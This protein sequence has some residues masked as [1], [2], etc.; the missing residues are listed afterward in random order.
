VRVIGFPSDSPPPDREAWSA[1]LDAALQG[2]SSGPVAQSWRELSEDVRS[3]APSMTPAFEARMRAELERAGALKGH[4]AVAAAPEARRDPLPLRAL[5]RL[6]RAP[7]KLTAHRGP[8]LAGTALA[9]VAV[10]AAVLAVRPSGSAPPVAL[11]ASTQR[12]P[13]LASPGAVRAEAA[14]STATPEVPSASVQSGQAGAGAPGRVQQVGAS[15]T[16]ASTPANVQALSDEVGQMAVR[17]G[18]YVQSSNVQVQQGGASEAT[19]ALRLPSARLGAELAALARLAPVRAETQAEQDITDSYNAARRALGDAVAE[20]QALLRALAAATSEGQIASL[21]ERLLDAR[22]AIVRAQDAFNAIS[23]R[24]S[25]AEVEVSILGDERAGAEGLT[26]RRGLRDAGHVLL[27]TVSAI[28]IA[29]AVLVPIALVGA[30]VLG[31]R[32]AVIRRRREGA[33]DTR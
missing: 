23:A 5:S 13:D 2:E 29:A 32:R 22:G 16:L 4:P 12:V 33:L 18:G 3:L 6:R 10:A 1:E 14:P 11:P 17:D 25:T 19:L 8:A 15:L 21:R 26:L 31:A 9:A 27:V 24:A 20:R 30:I 28:L 7:A